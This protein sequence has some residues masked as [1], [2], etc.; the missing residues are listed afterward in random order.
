MTTLPSP[1]PNIMEV[2]HVSCIETKRALMIYYSERLKWQFQSFDKFAIWPDFTV[3]TRLHNLTRFHSFDQLGKI[4]PGF[5]KVWPDLIRP[6]NFTQIWWFCP[7]LIILTRVRG[8]MANAS[9][10]SILFFNTS[11][12]L[13]P[14]LTCFDCK[15]RYVFLQKDTDK[16]NSCSVIVRQHPVPLLWS[17][18][19]HIWFSLK[20]PSCTWT[21]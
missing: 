12:I 2:Y 7:K 17:I 3:L 18:F 11:L 16:Q 21:F 20:A 13:T 4:W 15:I 10:I 8:F 9:K 5:S 6:T 19:L 14:S 1:H